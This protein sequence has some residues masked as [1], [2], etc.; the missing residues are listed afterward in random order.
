MLTILVAIISLIL[1]M[2]VVRLN[3]VLSLLLVAVGTGLSLGM[4]PE[5]TLTSIEKGVGSTLGQLALVLGLGAMLGEILSLT[6]ATQSLTDWLIKLFGVKN[7]RWAVLLAAFIIGIPMFYNAAFVVLFPLVA[8]LAQA[9]GLPILYLGLPMVAALSV[10]HGFLPPHPAPTAVAGIFKAD[11]GKT[12]LLGLV[13]ALP[14]ALIGG[15][16]LSRFFRNHPA[17]LRS[18]FQFSEKKDGRLP[19]PW[20]SLGA[21]LSPVLLIGAASAAAAFFEKGTTAANWAAFFSN[22]IVALTISVLLAAWFLGVRNGLAFNELMQK[23][24]DSTKSIAL[25]LLVIAAGGA[26]KQVLT[27]SGIGSELTDFFKNTSLPPLILAW[28]VAGLLRVALGSSTVAGMMAAGIVAP[29][30]DAGTS[31]ELLTLSVGAGSVLFSNVNDTGFWMFKEYFG[32]SVGQTFLS[33]SVMET[34]VSVV[35]LAMVLGL[36][37][38][39]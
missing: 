10:T 27:D 30:A 3:A 38:W 35:G 1:L 13:V 22:P 11:I 34:V 32:L 20:L 26:F 2:L 8:A 15:I 29:L 33:W 12:L 9:S 25:I 5:N 4:S 7:I 31:R 39:F 17:R 23:M 14:S 6:G 16:F 36:S 24:G 21:A 28:S 18:D 19:A 37:I